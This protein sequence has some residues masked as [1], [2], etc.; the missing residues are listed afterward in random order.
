MADGRVAAPTLAKA[1]GASVIANGRVARNPHSLLR[2]VGRGGR[3]R[4]RPRK[5][6]IENGRP[7]LGGRVLSR[8]L[9]VGHGS[10]PQTSGRSVSNCPSAFSLKPVPTCHL[11]E[12]GVSPG[13]P[14]AAGFLLPALLR[15]STPLPVQG[16]DFS[17]RW[18]PQWA[19]SDA[20]AWWR[21]EREKNGGGRHAGVVLRYVWP[22]PQ[23][24]RCAPSH[25]V[26]IIP[27]QLAD[28]RADLRTYRPSH[29]PSSRRAAGL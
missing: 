18:S 9:P 12:P 13:P 24:P 1:R 17:V 14:A 8:R 23:P 15:V 7:G 19:E 25:P 11:G 20:E 28:G 27:E 4:K 3:G 29:R 10:L 26:R 16:G 6:T 22:P 5:V 21:A 2:L